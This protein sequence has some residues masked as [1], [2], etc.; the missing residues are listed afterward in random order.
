MDKKRCTHDQYITPES[1]K[2]FFDA[3]PPIGYYLGDI[4]FASKCRKCGKDIS[5]LGLIRIDIED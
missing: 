3:E 5:K 1:F 4:Q 2:Q